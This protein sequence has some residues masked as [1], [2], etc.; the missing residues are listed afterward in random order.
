MERCKI[1]EDFVSK[2]GEL[3]IFLSEVA[4]W[5]LLE[6]ATHDHA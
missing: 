6:C 3:I 5:S 2:I 4:D 1:L